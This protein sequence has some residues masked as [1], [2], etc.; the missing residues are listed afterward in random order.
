MTSV[1]SEAR[2]QDTATHTQRTT[3]SPRRVVLCA[4]H[5][6]A[7]LPGAYASE[8]A[9]LAPW[10]ETHW[11]QDLGLFPCA[12]GLA[13]AADLPLVA[14]RFSRLLLDPN[15]KLDAADLIPQRI[16]GHSLAPLAMGE[17]RRRIR[18]LYLPY[19]RALRAT[20][21]HH[22]PTL[23]LSLHSFTADHPTGKRQG[24]LGVLFDYPTPLATELVAKLCD[25]G[26]DARPNW[27]Y[28][29]FDGFVHSAQM[30][31]RFAR[32]P[33]YLELEFRQDLLAREDFVQA[34]VRSLVPW[35]ASIPARHELTGLGWA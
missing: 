4:E 34:L 29:G 8:T 17:R 18:E 12:Q 25:E 6:G 13:E 32:I 5:A 24:E 15:R 30:H 35:L 26:F 9:E 7:R 1:Q 16:E 19:H 11:G 27:P 28:S 10:L 22:T 14:A 3:T 21:L 33:D 2:W 23:L 31:A 20:C